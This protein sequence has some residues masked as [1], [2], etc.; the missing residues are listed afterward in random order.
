M[1]GTS[2]TSLADA[3]ERLEPVLRENDSRTTSTL[4]TELYA[5]AG[6]LDGSGALRRALTDPS[7]SGRDKADLVTR[8]LRGQVGELAVDVAGSVARE[9]WA[10]DRD[11][12][13]ALEQLG[14]QSLLA[15]AESDGAMD[16]VE[17]EVFRF[18]RIIEGDRRLS[19]ALGDR[20]ADP[21]QRGDLVERLLEGKAHPVSQ[22]LARQAAVAPRGDTVEGAIGRVLEAAAE[23]RRRLVA[24][25][26][27]AVP[28][29]AAQVDRLASALTSMY[30]RT[31]VVEVDVDPSVVGGMR[32]TVG[33]E[34]IEGT[35]ATRM[36]E[37]KRSL[38]R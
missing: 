30:G 18:S 35:I 20:N 17:D 3:H 24:I 27:A 14:T 8:L 25:A 29:T 9:R 34:A 36:D 10:Q 13:D 12:A 4:G 32:V 7:R 22:A 38:T 23:R 6:L 26:T 1:R 21:A 37:A 33:D 28:L 31:V 5:V 15:S 2:R 11:V 16:R 19:G